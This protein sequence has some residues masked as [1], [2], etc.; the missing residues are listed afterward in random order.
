M[1][2]DIVIESFGRDE[3]RGNLV[4]VQP[5]L[6][7]GDFASAAAYRAALEP[8]L[9]QAA[10]S[11]F[12]GA[13]TV[14]VFPEGI[15]TWL[16]VLD[17]PAEVFDVAS[18]TEMSKK[19]AHQHKFRAWKKRM[20]SKAENRPVDA[21]FHVKAPA[22]A[23]TY[24]ATFSALAEKYHVT[25]VAGSI[26]IPSP[27][28]ADG[29][30]QAGQGPMHEVT[31]VY[32]PDGRAFSDFTLEL[33]PSDAKRGVVVPG[34]RN[35]APVLVTN[36]GRLGV[37]I[38]ADGM[39]PDSYDGLA[40]SGIDVLAAPGGLFPNERWDA[41]WAG[42]SGGIMPVDVE[43]RDVGVLTVGQAQLKYGPAGRAY[44]AGIEAMVQPFL[45]GP[46]WDVPTNGRMTALIASDLYTLQPFAGT[47][48]L[49]VWL[50]EAPIPPEAEE[51]WEARQVEE[52][53][54]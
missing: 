29:H 46:L 23:S 50:G 45:A 44:D 8:A 34:A 38:G 17:E 37:L 43:P 41:P 20:A 3:G 36:A 47:A 13:N 9:Q 14:V 53:R 7:P 11:G 32:G 26:A 31:V 22:M 18:V 35:E 40:A 21:V 15:G 39:Y 54:D 30:L 6:V 12:I 27:I 2:P 51:E 4:G 33:R 1:T 16:V 49:N 48:V 19:V 42:Y 24:D 28:V 52:Q 5:W 25:I 10:E